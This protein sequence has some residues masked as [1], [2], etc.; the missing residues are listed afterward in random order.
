MGLLAPAVVSMTRSV[1]LPAS[2]PL[3]MPKSYVSASPAARATPLLA[4]VA[5][6]VKSWW[7]LVVMPAMAAASVVAVSDVMSVRAMVITPGLPP[8]AGVYV[9]ESEP[10]PS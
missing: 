4:P 8:E 7:P 2:R 5:E 10:A 3:T 9:A 6:A 1:A